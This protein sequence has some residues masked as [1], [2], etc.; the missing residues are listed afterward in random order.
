MISL[1]NGYT[2]LA[3][4]RGD[5][6]LYA[7]G[8]EALILLITP[9]TARGWRALQWRPTVLLAA[10][11][12]AA[13]IG[14]NGGLWPLFHAPLAHPLG[15]AGRMALRADLPQGFIGRLFGV[16]AGQW[17]DWLLYQGTLVAVIALALIA[18]LAGSPVSRRVL[19]L[20]A[21]PFA[22]GAVI[23]LCSL[24][25]PPPPASAGNALAASPLVLFLLAAMVY[26]LGHGPRAGQHVPGRPAAPGDA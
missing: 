11:T 4:P 21:I 3:G 6:T 23:Y 10:A 24:I 25:S 26:W 5:V 1:T 22:L 16:G 9:G 13:G 8:L 18:M 14:I 12:V 17:G 19:A 20:L 15:L 7:Y 2:L